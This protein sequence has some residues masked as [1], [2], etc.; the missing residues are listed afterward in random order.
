MSPEMKK[1]VQDS[2]EEFVGKE[3]SD[4]FEIFFH[5]KC[6]LIYLKEKHRVRE[7]FIKVIADLD[8]RN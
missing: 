5:A 7:G 3:D 1:K 6:A 2:V 8:S 4:S